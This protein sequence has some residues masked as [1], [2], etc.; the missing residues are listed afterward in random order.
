MMSIDVRI[1]NTIDTTKGFRTTHDAALSEYR[2]PYPFETA[3]LVEGETQEARRPKDSKGAKLDPDKIIQAFNTWAFKREQPHTPDLLRKVVVD[4]VAA[5]EPIPFVLYWGKGPRHDIAAP[6][7]ECLDYLRTMAERVR[8]TYPP[9]AAVKLIF[10]DTHAALNGHSRADMAAYFQAVGQAAA[11][12]GFETCL[13]S[14]ITTALGHVEVSGELPSEGVLAN[15][16]A[17]AAKW[18]RGGGTTEEGALEYFRMNMV[19]RRAVEAAFPGSVFVTF[20]NSDFRELFPDRL[21]IF[22]MYSLRR[23]FGV[24]PWFITAA[25][26]ADAAAPA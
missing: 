22:Y 21:P 11:W 20:N 2:L 17:S 5:G 8:T 19:E 9:G 16:R 3:L 12:R 4:A 26:A 15:L 7:Q 1:S 18:Y 23:G 24:K 25:P 10:T 13:L 6:D 14:D